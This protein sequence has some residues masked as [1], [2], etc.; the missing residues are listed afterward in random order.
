MLRVLFF[1]ILNDEPQTDSPTPS[2]S[3]ST[4]A[5]YLCQTISLYLAWIHRLTVHHHLLLLLLLVVLG[6]CCR[7]PLIRQLYLNPVGRVPGL[8]LS[9]KTVSL[10]KQSP[11][12]RVFQSRRWSSILFFNITIDVDNETKL[13]LW[14]S[15]GRSIQKLDQ[16]DVRTSSVKAGRKAASSLALL[17]FAFSASRL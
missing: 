1:S 8:R 6:W 14:C 13:L 16:E 17:K 2:E 15:F 5:H 10:W 11:S 3:V 12:L 7:R 4:L 9:H